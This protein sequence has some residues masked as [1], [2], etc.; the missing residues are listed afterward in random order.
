MTQASNMGSGDSM[1]LD[2]ATAAS[3][4]NPPKIYIQTRKGITDGMAKNARGNSMET[5]L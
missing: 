2:N 4:L 1:I 5:R 3:D